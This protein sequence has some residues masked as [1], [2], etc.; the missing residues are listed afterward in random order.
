MPFKTLNVNLY[1]TVSRFASIV[2]YIFFFFFFFFLFP[3]IGIRLLQRK[4]ESIIPTT[5]KV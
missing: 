5:H 2:S 4:T 1:I 3:L